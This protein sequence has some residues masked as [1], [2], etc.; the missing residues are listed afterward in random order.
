MHQNG[1]GNGNGVV[2]D[3]I[4][5]H[6]EFYE[7]VDGQTVLPLGGELS[8]AI[9]G[10]KPTRSEIKIKAIPVSATGQVGHLDDNEVYTFLVSAR[11]DKV[12]FVTKRDIDGYV[13]E[14]KRVQTLRPINIRPLSE[15]EAQPLLDG[16]LPI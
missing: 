3:S 1:N 2:P 15:G 6:A 4:E 5:A 10:E 9:G 11:V 14:K 16:S 13:V 7:G 8:L 12:E